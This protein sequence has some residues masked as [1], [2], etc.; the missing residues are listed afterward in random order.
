MP[1]L[2]IILVSGTHWDREWYRTFQEFRFRLVDILDELLVVLGREEELVF[3]LDGNTLTLEDYLE[4]RPEKRPELEKYIGQGRLRVGPW[5]CMPDEF[6]VSGES[7]IRNL[8]AGCAAARQ[9]GGEPV[10]NGYLCDCFGHTAQMPQILAG[11]GIRQAVVGRGTNEHTT[12]AFFRWRAPDGSECLTFKLADLGGYGDFFVRGVRP[13][14]GGLSDDELDGTLRSAVERERARTPLPVVALFDATDHMPVHPA[15]VEIAGRLRRLYPDAQVTFGDPESVVAAARTAAEAAGAPALPVI[16]GDLLEPAKEWATYLC[17][18]PHTLSSRIDIKQKNDRCQT[19]LE[20]WA[21][22]LSALAAL[23]KHPLPVRFEALAWQYLLK[24]QAHDSICGCSIDQVHRD[25]HYRF[26]QSRQIAEEMTARLFGTLLPDA[27][28]D[29]RPFGALAVL[30]PLPYARDEVIDAAVDFP[31]DW[32]QRYSEPFGYEDI[33]SFQLYDMDGHPVPYTLHSVSRGG[34]KGDQHCFSFRAALAPMGFTFFRL[35]PRD[36]PARQP[37]SLRTGRVSADNGLVS[38]AVCVDGTLKLTDKKTG[39]TYSGLCALAD[40]AEIGD[41]WFHAMPVEN[42]EAVSAAASVRVIADGPSETVFR[43]VRR[44]AVPAHLE[45]HD[46]R[47][48]RIRRSEEEAVLTVTA[49]IH[50]QDGLRGVKVELA[51]DNTAQDHRLRLLL[52]TGLSGDYFASGAF[53]MVKRPGSAVFDTRDWREPEAPEKPMHGIVGRRGDGAGLAFVSGCCGLHE[54]A[55][56]P[57]DEGTIAVTLLRSFAKTE[58]TDLEK[59]GQVPGEFRYSFQLLPLDD[60]VTDA[61]L[62]RAQDALAAGVRISPV[63]GPAAKVQVPCSFL[64]LTGDSLCYSTMT[65]GADENSV[66][67]RVYNLSDTACAGTL[68]WAVPP[69]SAARVTL[70]GEVIEEIVPQGGSVPLCPGPW[71]IVSCLVRFPTS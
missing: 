18:I 56:L 8:Q 49:D 40:D 6:L 25:M 2:Q 33:N 23:K 67:V 59:D 55:A 66:T 64:R 38:V 5:Y 70:G 14:L 52:P 30:N 35:E 1:Q 44:M 24:N 7:L 34:V 63:G 54:C 42:Q 21:V 51:V 58:G 61:A 45:R 36:R 68:E 28:P 47:M 43:V 32:A 48:Q 9:F 11:F 16:D 12:P 69:A 20:K 27:P 22:P 37:G 50:V 53:V 57:G 19:L 17:V 3:L 60:G 71:E 15:L 65:A 29:S 13:M 41:G 4:I 39:R 62:Q 26:D 31:P 10:R 46:R